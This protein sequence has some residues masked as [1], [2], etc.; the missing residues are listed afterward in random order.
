[1]LKYFALA[2]VG[3][4]AAVLLVAAFRPDTFEV[5]RSVTI[6]A[7]PERVHALINDLHQ[8]NSWNPF[9]KK[10]PNMRGTYRGPAAGPGAAFDFDGN[11][12]VGKGTVAITGSQP[13]RIAMKL[14]ML[15]PMKAHNDVE[16]RLEP[17]GAHTQVTWAMRGA[18]PYLG[19]LVG[20]VFDMDKMVGGA[21]E[22][23]LADLKSLAERR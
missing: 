13:Q 11:S 22:S 10:D 21:F 8:F 5:Q 18:S 14:D 9:N 12:E 1:M 19:K 16:F 2:V 17:T 7:P 6:A 15:A 23:G 4:I 20:M 3:L